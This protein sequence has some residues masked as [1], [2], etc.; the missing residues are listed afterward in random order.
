MIFCGDFFGE[1]TALAPLRSSGGRPRL[2]EQ[3]TDTVNVIG[4]VHRLGSLGLMSGR[5]S[6]PLLYAERE[7]E[8]SITP[9]Q[10]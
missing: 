7:R 8:R 2:R 6:V 3:M 1:I 4:P 10:P 5:V 9:I